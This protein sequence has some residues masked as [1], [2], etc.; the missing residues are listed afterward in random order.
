M[1]KMFKPC[2]QIQVMIYCF[3]SLSFTNFT[4]GPYLYA[5]GNLQPLAIFKGVCVLE[6]VV[7]GAPVIFPT[8][9]KIGNIFKKT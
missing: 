4:E 2:S 3:S 9:L 6:G 5:S 7:V 8:P 1:K